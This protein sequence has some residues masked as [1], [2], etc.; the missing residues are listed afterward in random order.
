MG[1][2]ARIRAFLQALK[3]G[4]GGRLWRMKKDFFTLLGFDRPY[5]DF[6]LLET[7]KGA[8]RFFGPGPFRRETAPKESL[9]PVFRSLGKNRRAIEAACL[10]EENTDFIFRPFLLCGKV[11][12]LAVFVNGMAD[13]ETINDFILKGAMLPRSLPKGE[14][15]RVV[16]EQVFPMQEAETQGE[17]DQVVAALCEG[18]TAVFLEGAGQAVLLDPRGF[19]SRSIES[20][21]NENVVVGPH[22]G[23][24]EN[25]R[26]GVTQLRRILKRPDFVCAF[27]RAGGKNGTK[28]A[29]CYLGGVCNES[30]L[31]EVKKRLRQVDT[32]LILSAGTLEQLLEDHSLSPIPQILLTERPDRAAAAVMEGRVA[33]LVE[34]SPQALVLPVTLSA[35]L[36]S[37]EDDYLRRPLGTVI[38]VVRLAGALL[39][40]LLPAWFLALATHHQGLLNSQVLSTVVSS[41]RLVFMPL[42]LEVIFLLMVFQ[43][44]RE[45]GIR[46]PGAVGQTVG[47]IGGLI[48][49]QAAVSANMVSTVVLIIV[50]LAGLGNFCIPDY[51]MQLAVS[52]Y[53]I[54][55]CIFAG[56]AGLLGTFV[57]LMASL[58]W[59]CS[60]KSFGVPFMSPF[61]PKTRSRAPLLFR[62]SLRRP[63]GGED[64]INREASL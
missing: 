32:E 10:A 53:R 8:P 51:S 57:L 61:A 26:T 59:L 24:T 35:L 58:A 38:R 48:L 25:L 46:V 49:G 22:E 54:A 23:F 43:L 62:G 27:R 5:T 1:I 6:E 63:G 52:W 15:T 17:L 29:L 50:A 16:M 9:G 19:A 13:G 34:G 47:I 14:L 30:L 21:Q 2:Y 18:R 37:P 20:S 12:A 28:L 3:P 39:S 33:I 11:P 4:N 7:E 41:R 55:L 60:Q 45:A 64:V 40:V 42:P 44:V 31:Q 56:L 36:T